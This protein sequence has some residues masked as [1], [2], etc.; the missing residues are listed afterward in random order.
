MKKR[1]KLYAGSV[2]MMVLFLLGLGLISYPVV[3]NWYYNWQF[4]REIGEYDQ[5]ANVDCDA[6][7]SAAREYNRE[8]AEKES[9]FSVSEEEKARITTL[10]NPLG[11]G[12][13]G[14]ID[15]PKIDVHLPIYQGTEE[16]YLQAGAGWWFGTSLPTGGEST[17]C[18]L[19][20]HNGL[21]KAKMFTD[22]DQLEM[23]DIF[24]LTI[25]DRV[26]SYQ[27]D[28]ILV[29]EPD[30]LEPLYIQEG[31]DYVTL[32]TCTPYGVNTHRLLVRGTRVET[33]ASEAPRSGRRIVLLA[34]SALVLVVVAVLLL[35]LVSCSCYHG[36]REIPKYQNFSKRRK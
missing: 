5:F 6:L 23:G 32:Y 26:L 20:A 1:L 30:D 12:M 4:Q 19:A 3:S 27:V 17:H 15:I 33:P 28:Q 31:G 11:N 29:V 35:Y 13:M 25:L 22:L 9:Q 34:A 8:L 36:K 7:W 10:L 16:K 24:S 2:C 14:Y 21:V 18:V